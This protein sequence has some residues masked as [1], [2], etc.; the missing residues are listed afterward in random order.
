MEEKIT[1]AFEVIISN[2]AG[3]PWKAIIVLVAC[4]GLCMGLF[5]LFSPAAAIR[6]QQKFYAKIN[7]RMEPISLEKEIRN[8]RLMGISLLGALLAILLFLAS[9][10][11]TLF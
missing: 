7:W 9:A 3:L 2:V 1:T 4:F 8:T 6:L 10:G 11:K 5:L